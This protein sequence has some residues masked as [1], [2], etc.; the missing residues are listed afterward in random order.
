[1][2][3]N[4]VL[5]CVLLVV[6]L[7]MVANAA[8]D[9]IDF[10]VRKLHEKGPHD[11]AMVIAHRG[12]WRFGPENSLEGF[13]NCIRSGFDAIEVDVRMT[14][15]GVL[16]AMHDETVNRTTNGK[17]KVSDLTYAEI[18]KLRL[19]TPTDY[20][21]DQ[22]VPSFEEVLKLAKGKILILVDKW[23]KYK[24]TVLDMVHSLGMDRQILLAGTTNMNSD[25]YKLAMQYP[26][27]NYVP[28]MQCNGKNDE[29][30]FADL[31]EKMHPH[32]YFIA[33]PSDK[34]PIVK[35][36]QKYAE[37]GHRLWVGTMIGSCCNGGHND[38]LGLTDAEASYGWLLDHGF[39]VFFT[40]NPHAVADYLKSRNMR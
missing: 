29:S 32:G 9:R 18:K 31:Q 11:Y 35:A 7:Q 15:D 6:L 13:E 37:F 21:S 1:M 17:G 26:E 14:R 30:L 3:M 16:V 25:T 28:F 33:F 2:Y 22:R 8:E 38:H 24:E 39:T 27:V 23:S 34:F 4:N 19:K 20:L 5:K 40:D 10:L 36:A 12:D